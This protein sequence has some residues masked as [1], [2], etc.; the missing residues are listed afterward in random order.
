MRPPTHETI[1]LK[2]NFT[3]GRGQP[4]TDSSTVAG[5][6][7]GLGRT[8]CLAWLAIYVQIPAMLAI[9]STRKVDGTAQS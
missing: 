7:S 2:C 4:V 3:G 8:A 6:R 1:S 5:I 9:D